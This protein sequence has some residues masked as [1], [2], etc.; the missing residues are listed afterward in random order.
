MEVF[1]LLKPSLRGCLYKKSIKT[2]IWK[3]NE[4]DLKN[5]VK[6]KPKIEN[7]NY[8]NERD[9]IKRMTLRDTRSWFKMRSRM[10]LREDMSCRHCATGITETQQH[11][12]KCTGLTREQRGLKMDTDAG[13]Q[14]F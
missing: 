1:F 8:R 14:I 11:L 7:S 3:K 13:Q 6:N 4:K 2:A 9:Y 10:T 12:E 5:L